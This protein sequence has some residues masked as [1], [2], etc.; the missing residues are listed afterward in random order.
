MVVVVD[1]L[2]ATTTLLTAVDN[3]ASQVFVA[4][5]VEQAWTLAELLGKDV[6]LGG[7][8]NGTPIEHFNLGPLPLEYSSEVIG[9]KAVVYVSTNG[10]PT[11][12][13]AARSGNPVF[14]SCLRNAPA[15]S[16]YLSQ[17]GPSDVYVVGSGSRGL[18]ALED[19]VCAGVIACHLAVRTP[20]AY[21][22]A[23]LAAMEIVQSRPPKE[24]VLAGRVG[25]ALIRHGLEHVV[26]FCSEIGLSE[27]V[28]SLDE[29]SRLIR[30]PQH[31]A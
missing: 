10:T 19:F 8:Q 17:L 21:N 23:A 22:D 14:L 30:T 2:L 15:V 6:I 27:T 13:A 12:A 5:T 4:E 16:A 24:W 25:R 29:R 1:V 31:R 26:E 9:Q 7:E 3:G 28:L 20:A 18:L 11:V